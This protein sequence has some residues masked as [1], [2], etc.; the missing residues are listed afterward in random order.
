MNICSLLKKSC[1][2]FPISSSMLIDEHLKFLVLLLSPPPFL[3]VLILLSFFS[4]RW[5]QFGD[6]V[7]YQIFTF[8]GLIGPFLAGIFTTIFLEMF[9]STLQHLFFK[10]FKASSGLSQLFV[11]DWMII[12]KKLGEVFE[13]IFFSQKLQLLLCRKWIEE[14]VWNINVCIDFHGKYFIEHH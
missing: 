13:L 1:Y 3:Y 14:F 8:F 9:Q 5:L 7:I 6:N 10:G 2:A 11:I 12:S 4:I